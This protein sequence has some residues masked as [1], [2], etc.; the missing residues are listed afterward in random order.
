MTTVSGLWR[1]L[2]SRTVRAQVTA[3]M[4]SGL[5]TPKESELRTGGWRCSWLEAKA[6]AGAGR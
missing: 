4:D 6:E 3:G 5:L 2:G 1:G